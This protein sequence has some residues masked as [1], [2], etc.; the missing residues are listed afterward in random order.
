[1]KKNTQ[2]IL[3]AL[4]AW[5]FAF[6][7][8]A[9]YTL[10]NHDTPYRNSTHGPRCCWDFKNRCS[11]S[12]SIH[13]DTLL[14]FHPCKEPS[15]SPCSLCDCSK[16]SGLFSLFEHHPKDPGVGS[17]PA[18][19]YLDQTRGAC[20]VPAFAPAVEGPVIRASLP[21]LSVFHPR[22]G[23]LPF[24]PRAPPP[25]LTPTHPFTV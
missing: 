17:C 2:R 6:L 21:E 16:N 12:S 4:F 25:C 19:Q 5:W 7:N 24:F 13:Q 22:T 15:K 3:V 8:G 9:V 14:C 1:M 23:F 10:H 20:P 18:C 11:L